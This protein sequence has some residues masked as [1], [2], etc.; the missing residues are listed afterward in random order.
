VRRAANIDVNHREIVD[1]LRAAGASVQPLHT[2]GAGCPDLLV[3][4]RGV[5]HVLEVKRPLSPRGG[6][7]RSALTPDQQIWHAHWRGNVRVVRSATEALAAIG[8]TKEA[9]K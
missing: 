2:V 1:A 3:G 7:S 9:T 4:A 8:A 6:A 5:N